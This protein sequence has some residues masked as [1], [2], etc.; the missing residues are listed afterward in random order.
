MGPIGVSPRCSGPAALLHHR[1]HLA[2]D[3]RGAVQVGRERVRR[4]PRRART[5][6]RAG[7]PPRSAGTAPSAARAMRLRRSRRPASAH[8]L[9]PTISG[10]RS[11]GRPRPA[12]AARPSASS[13][14][15]AADGLLRATAGRSGCTT[16]GSTRSRGRAW[17]GSRSASGCTCRPRAPR[18]CPRGRSASRALAAP[19]GSVASMRLGLVD[20]RLD[21]LVAERGDVRAGVAVRVDGAAAEQHVQEV[22][23]RRVVLVPG[24]PGRR[25]TWRSSSSSG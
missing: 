22:R 18:R 14:S 4:A 13:E 19:V 17:T 12:R 15:A 21:G 11:A 1:H 2:V 7:T 25:S 10:R 3:D 9:R 6:A 24:R 5:A 23:R 8:G 20:L 16:A